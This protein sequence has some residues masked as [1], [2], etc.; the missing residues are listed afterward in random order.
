[1]PLSFSR[2]RLFGIAA[3]MTLAAASFFSPVRAD[4]FA[5]D[6]PDL[7]WIDVG[8]AYNEATTDVAM[9]GPNGIGATVNFEDVFDL[10]GTKTTARMLGSARISAHRRYIDFGYCDISRRATR[11]LDKDVEFGDYTYHAGGEV[12]TRFGTQFTYAAFRYDFLHENKVRISGSAGL[13]ALRLIVS[14]AGESGF[15][16]DANGNPVTSSF[17]RKGSVTAPVPMVGINLDWA[18]TNRL[19]LRTY[20]RFFKINVSAFNG[21]LTEG[22]IRLNWYFVKHFGLGLGYDRSFLNVKELKVGNGNIV[23][24]SYDVTGIGLFANLAF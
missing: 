6:V 3:V 17:E 10:P 5:G 22:G 9:R 23:K 16:D 12:R 7:V 19:V 21:G 1:M 20:T 4:D 15:V 2:V 11:V 14:V 13:T 24:A 8:G 18:L